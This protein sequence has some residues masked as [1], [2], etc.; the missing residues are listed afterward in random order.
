MIPP[1]L[2]AQETISPGRDSVVVDEI[3]VE[4]NR[5]KMTNSTAPNKIQLLDEKFI[6]SLNGRSL[7]DALQQSDAVFV[8]DYGFN[9]GSKT[10][11]LN[12][13]QS[14]HTLIL[15]NGVRLNSRQNAQV[16]LSLFNMDNVSKIE[17]SKGGSSALY[18]SEAIGGV[19]NIIT[20]NPNL[21]KLISLNLKTCIGSYGLRSIYGNF[22][23]SM[24]LNSGK[25]IS[26]SLSYS[27]ERAKNNF[28]YMFKNG[29]I[30]SRRERENS[31]FNSQAFN[32]DLTYTPE[33][34]SSL[35]LFTNYSHFERGVPGIDLGYSTG[36]ARQIDYNFI[37][38]ISYNRK[39]N[40][41]LLLKSDFGYNYAL[42]K[43][44]DPS[45]FNLSVKINSYYKLNSIVTSHSM[46][47]IPS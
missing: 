17:V 29:Q 25:S 22:S 19:I 36:T 32:F 44:F 23:H 33:K 5:L 21:N 16:D 13:T 39:I 31:E 35:K 34:F 14:E 4:S 47:Y 20:K 18:G 2:S 46:S 42:Q 27:D 12:A 15:L 3:L 6:M 38:S 30:E 37:S 8:K 7:N 11:S 24:G 9:S 26:Y 28:E 10:I 43:Y 41:K 45:T 40:E 1:A